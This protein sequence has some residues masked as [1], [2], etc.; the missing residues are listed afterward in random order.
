MEE[1][2][3][4]FIKQKGGLKP[5]CLIQHHPPNIKPSSPHE[6]ENH[7][8]NIMLLFQTKIS[9]LPCNSQYSS[10]WIS[11][12]RDPFI[13]VCKVVSHLQVFDQC[14]SNCCS[15]FHLEISWISYSS[16]GKFREAS[17]IREVSRRFHEHLLSKMPWTFVHPRSSHPTEG[18]I[19][20]H[21][22][23]L[24][25]QSVCIAP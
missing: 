8:K 7:T 20:M 11:Q 9:S 14:H 18:L 17:V 23:W 22:T 13:D 2:L 24:V 16:L 4:N 10:L 6:I 3:K 19:S 5:S 1:N 25:Q 15:W 21:H 12:M